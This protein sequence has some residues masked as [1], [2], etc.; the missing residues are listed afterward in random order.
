MTS[1]RGFQFL[2][3]PGPTPIPDRILNAM[4][5]QSVDFSSDDFMALCD[6]VF[7]DVKAVFQTEG[8]VHLYAANGHGAWE[9][10][11]A[12][13][14]SP[15]DKVVIPEVGVFS[16]AW[17]SMAEAMGYECLTIKNDWRTAIDNA[18]LEA[19]LRADT[20][21]EIKAVLYVHVDTATGIKS[22]V[23][24]ARA[25]ID[26]AGHPALFCV[27]T[28]ASLGTVEFPMDAWRVD[29]TVAA[30][31]KGLMMPP[32]LAMVATNDKAMEIGKTAKTGRRYWDWQERGAGAHYQRFCGTAPE[33]H[34]FGLREALNILA[35]DGLDATFAR[36][37]RLARAVR[38]CVARWCD[39]GPLEFNA[40][41]PEQRA[42]SV[43]TI[44]TPDG[45]DAEA[46][47]AVGREMNLHIG[48]GIGPYRGKAFRIGH[49][50][51]INEPMILGSLAAIETTLRRFGVPIGAGGL[52]AAIGELSS[53]I[54]AAANAA[55]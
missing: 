43:T 47:R 22:D 28:I 1:E 8:I 11:L 10:A 23:P 18:S 6:E 54:T 7:E 30:S 46:L 25:A 41:H 29:V 45:I 12:N 5:R 13:M 38:A 32:G 40:I 39:G 42:D 27:D 26:A 20:A 2:L 15:G 36:H 33:H 53:P 35:E 16:E 44:L 9:A 48:A 31:Q 55:E 50:G 51:D 3:S 17:R 49:M 37:E 14:L 21:H 4:H 52:D 34:I 24:G 19:I